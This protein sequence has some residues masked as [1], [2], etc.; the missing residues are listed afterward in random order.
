MKHKI[1]FSGQ[2]IDLDR[3]QAEV[4]Q[5]LTPPSEIRSQMCLSKDAQ[6]T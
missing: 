4:E 5:G 6:Y 1:H 2:A 3:S